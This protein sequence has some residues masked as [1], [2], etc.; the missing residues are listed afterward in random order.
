MKIALLGV[1]SSLLALAAAPPEGIEVVRA[2]DL[3]SAEQLRLEQAAPSIPRTGS[4]E[5]LLAGEV[6]AVVVTRGQDT[7]ARV[8]QVRR[9]AA[10]GVPLLVSHPLSSSSL[11]LYEVE[12]AQRDGKA[13]LVPWLAA[14]KNSILRSICDAIEHDTGAIDQLIFERA[15]EDRNPEVVWTALARDLDLLRAVC[16]E[17]NRVLATGPREKSDAK[18]THFT[19]HLSGPNCPPV[20]WSLEPARGGAEGRLIFVRASGE[21]VYHLRDGL[22]WHDADPEVG[23][24]E[25]EGVESGSSA[26]AA[27]Q[28]LAAAMAGATPRPALTD[29]V[30]SVE[31]LEAVGQ[32]RRVGAERLGRAQPHRAV[33]LGLDRGVDAAADAR[34]AEAGPGA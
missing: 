18:I 25:E 20:R 15:L 13:A 21:R 12:L 33:G 22:W 16:G 26:A 8:A 11:D 27:F 19:V 31:L 34:R 32:S 28:Y 1:D 4:W 6:D 30:R 7:A 2:A 29:A 24:G 9:L 14:R 17:L 10:E 23:G 5:T 3:T